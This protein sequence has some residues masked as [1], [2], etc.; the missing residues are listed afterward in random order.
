MSECTVFVEVDWRNAAR[1]NSAAVVRLSQ[2]A[3]LPDEIIRRDLARA[4][5]LNSKLVRGLVHLRRDMLSF[6][7]MLNIFLE[8]LGSYESSDYPLSYEV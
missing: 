2:M 8:I 4:R 3:P 5:Q 1:K 7:L 6:L